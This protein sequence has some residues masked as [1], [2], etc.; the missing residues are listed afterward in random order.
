MLLTKQE[1]EQMKAIDI[2]EA[3]RVELGDI[4]KVTVDTSK[5]VTGRVADYMNKFHSPFLFHVG[6]YIIKLKYK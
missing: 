4:S 6:E 5:S 3:N 2:M 1:L